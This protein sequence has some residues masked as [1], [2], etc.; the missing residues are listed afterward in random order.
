MPLED[1]SSIQCVVCFTIIGHV[2]FDHL[3][4][5]E[6]GVDKPARW[7]GDVGNSWR[8]TPDIADNYRSMVGTIDMVRN[9]YHT[10]SFFFCRE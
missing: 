2:S 7:A 8:T 3:I 1:P 5:I 4:E 10:A 9:T 6:W